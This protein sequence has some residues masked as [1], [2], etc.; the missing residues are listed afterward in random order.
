MNE[1][2][3]FFRSSSASCCLTYLPNSVKCLAAVR[4]YERSQIEIGFETL[5]RKEPLFSVHSS[6]CSA[7]S[8]G[9]GEIENTHPD[10]RGMLSSSSKMTMA[11]TLL[12]KAKNQ[13]VALVP[14]EIAELSQR[15]WPLFNPAL[16]PH[17]PPPAPLANRVLFTDTEDE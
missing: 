1:C 4:A 5:H 6:P 11:A 9:L 10:S 3:V 7:E 2:V 8:D 14:K 16:Y 12:E 17:K 15:F 13:P